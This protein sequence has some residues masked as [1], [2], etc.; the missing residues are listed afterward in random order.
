MMK[1]MQGQPSQTVLPTVWLYINETPEQ[2][3]HNTPKEAGHTEFAL[4]LFAL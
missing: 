3:E 1:S 4:E 2:C